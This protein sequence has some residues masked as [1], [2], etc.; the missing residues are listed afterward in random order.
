[1]RCDLHSI[2][3]AWHNIVCGLRGAIY[4]TYVCVYLCIW[5]SYDVTGIRSSAQFYYKMNYVLHGN[6]IFILAELHLPIIECASGR[7]LVKKLS[8]QAISLCIGTLLNWTRWHVNNN[9]AISPKFIR[10]ISCSTRFLPLL[11]AICLY[12]YSCSTYVLRETQLTSPESNLN[13]F[14]TRDIFIYFR[15]NI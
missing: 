5:I 12:Y 3:N 14:T 6:I 11:F 9:S 4:C 2:Y 15:N 8:A 1:M 13:I 7:L 10:N